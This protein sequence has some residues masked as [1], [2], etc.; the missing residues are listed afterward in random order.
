M[1]LQ[2]D[3]IQSIDEGLQRVVTF[4]GFQLAGPQRERM[5]S[6]HFQLLT[7]FDVALHI[8]PYLLHPKGGV[9]LGYLAAL[10]ALNL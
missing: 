10:G 9:R 2:E 6:H 8:A 4:F 5:P 7:Y 1:I 3:A